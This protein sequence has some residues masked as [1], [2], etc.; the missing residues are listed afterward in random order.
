MNQSYNKLPGNFSVRKVSVEQAMR[1]LKRNG[2]Q[3]NKEKA[4]V[5]LDFLYLIAK[6]YSPIEDMEDYKGLNQKGLSNTMT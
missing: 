1:S 3:V 2:V 6:T 4:E 5:I